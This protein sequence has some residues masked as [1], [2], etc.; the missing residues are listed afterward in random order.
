MASRFSWVSAAPRNVRT[1]PSRS[2][3]VVGIVDHLDVQVSFFGTASSAG[4]I[5]VQLGPQI[6]DDL[7]DD[8]IHV[9]GPDRRPGGSNAAHTT[10]RSAD[11]ID[12]RYSSL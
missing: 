11:R 5:R 9:R 2:A 10:A 6:G 1:L 8:L 7:K 3:T 12:R 4:L